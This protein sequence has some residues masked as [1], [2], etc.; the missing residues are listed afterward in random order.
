M[1]DSGLCYLAYMEPIVDHVLHWNPAWGGL[2]LDAAPGS[3]QLVK[4][5]VINDILIGKKHTSSPGGCGTNVF[6]GIA[7]LE[8]KKSNVKVCGVL[9]KDAEV[10]EDAAVDE[11]AE[12]DD[13]PG[14]SKVANAAKVYREGLERLGIVSGLKV[15]A[16]KVTGVCLSVVTD[17]GQR[18]MYTDLGAAKELSIDHVTSEEI[19]AFADGRSLHMH[20]EGYTAFNDE[21]FTAAIKMA[22]AAGATVS[23]G[24]DGAKVVEAKKETFKALIEAGQIDILLGNELEMATYTEVGDIEH[25]TDDDAKAS[26][27]LIGKYVSTVVTTMGAEGCWIKDANGSVQKFDAEPVAGDLETTGAGDL[28]ASG[29]IF[30]VLHGLPTSTTASIAALMASAIIQEDGADLSEAGWAKIEAKIKV[31]TGD[32]EVG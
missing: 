19:V 31:L 14:A 30:G 15:S 27:E 18:T 28:F 5:A 8:G 16:S 7:L 10:D 22:K 32:D 2:P 25:L 6:Q 11:D 1:A 3:Q 26:C 4:I 29:I 13:V 17:D 23:V 20:F 12:V 24:L 21:F 9:G